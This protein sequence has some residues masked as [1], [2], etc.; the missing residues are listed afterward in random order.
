MRPEKLDHVALF[1]S[2]PDRVAAMVCAR[3]P[4]RVLER[5]DEF[6]AEQG[7][8]MNREVDAENSKAILR[9]RPR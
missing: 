7:F 9:S 6:R 2:D 8:Q 1:V 4:F 3:L 5:T